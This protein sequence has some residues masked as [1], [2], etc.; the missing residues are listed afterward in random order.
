MKHV[1][2]DI[3]IRWVAVPAGE[4]SLYTMP[5]FLN[6]EG[7]ALST[8]QG[9]WRRA[10]QEV[11]RTVLAPNAERID[12]EGVFPAENIRALGKAG[13]LGLLLPKEMGGGGEG[14]LTAV[15][16]TE[17][18]G[19]ACAATAMAYHMH[20][21]TIPLLVACATPEQSTLYLQRIVDEGWLG[22]FAMSEA[23]S[24]NR[25]W[26]MDSA[27]ER[28]NDGYVINSSK[29]FCTSAGFAD[30]YVVPTRS[31]P[32]ATPKD[33]S[34]FFILGTDPN[35][36]PIGTWDGM[37]LR[38]NGSRPITFD[39]C[40]VASNQRF[41]ED[42]SGLSFMMAYALPIYLCGMAAVYIGVA[43]AA[44]EAAVAHV[45]KRIH[46]D[47]GQSLAHVETVQRL[48]AEMRVTIDLVRSTTIRVAQMADNAIVLFNELNSSG[49]LDEVMRDNPD[50]PFFVEVATLKPAACEM[51][52]DVTNKAL[53]VCGGAGYKRGHVV[54]R[55]YRDA[56]A[57]SVMGPA[58]DTVKIVIGT[59][60]LG[61]P[62]PW[63]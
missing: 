11:A 22:A 31:G 18:L 46:S 35:I 16:V 14:V 40:V 20:Q 51:A 47:T 13:L 19:K 53:Q 30:Y 61:L 26:H 1:T 7:L 32:D 62:Q 8:D 5:G 54:E 41:G 37:G 38:G 43:T 29:S 60:I 50:D 3:D 36:R 17:Q 12:R 44:Y 28:V 59:Q 23:G 9:R 25:I 49:L 42:G 52:V 57:G 15:M 33:L 4:E 56:R 45:K 2:H 48:I 6:L 27:A 21:T 10:A 58:D 63:I 24:G 34:Q 55:A 39:N